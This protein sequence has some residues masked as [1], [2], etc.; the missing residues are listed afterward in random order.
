MAHRGR[1]V[2]DARRR[3]EVE[4]L[5]S[6]GKGVVENRIHDDVPRMQVKS[7]DRANLG[8]EG[9]RIPV[10][11]VVAEFKI[12]GVEEGAVVRV[13]RSKQQAN[14]AAVDRCAAVVGDAINRQIKS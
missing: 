4:A 1:I 13:W 12:H 6:A 14:L 10:P 9:S 11:G 8:C 5:E 2:G 3:G 7:E